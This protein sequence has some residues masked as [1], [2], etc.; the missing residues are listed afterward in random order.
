LHRLP[1]DTFPTTYCS[2]WWRVRRGDEGG[3]RK[4]WGPG[5]GRSW[6]KAALGKLHLPH[7]QWWL[8]AKFTHR[9]VRGPINLSI[10]TS[11]CYNIFPSC[12]QKMCPL[13]GRSLSS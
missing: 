11:F 3:F 8:L 13:S 5:L 1:R 7:L 10:C 2:W 6:G 4:V 12:Q 9:A